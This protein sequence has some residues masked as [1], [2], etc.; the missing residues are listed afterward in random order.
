[1]KQSYK[2]I[3]KKYKRTV[4]VGDI[5]GCFTE[6]EK[7]LKLISFSDD[8]LLIAVGD[9]V[10][11]G[12]RTWDVVRF[13]HDKPNAYSVLGNHDR[14]LAGTIYGT[15]QPAWSQLHSLAKLPEK[16]RLYWANFLG[17][18]PAVIEAE[19]AIVTHARLDP[20]RSIREQDPY[21]TCAVGGPGVI[22]EKN[23]NDIPLWFFEWKEV[24]RENKPICI[25]HVRYNNIELVQKQ[26]YALDTGA[27]NGG[28]L[29][30]VILPEYRIVQIKSKR[31]YYDEARL[32]WSA[33]ELSKFTPE[34]IPI[35]RYFSIKKKDKKN[36]CE[37]KIIDEFEKCFESFQFQNKIK[38]LRCKIVKIFGELPLPGPERGKYFLSIKDKFQHINHRIVSIILTPKAFRMEQFLR[39]FEG[40]NLLKACEELERIETSLDLII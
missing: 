19:H 4:V 15:S 24:V 14:R 10:D 37:E 36:K 17:S 35:H 31:N 32:E 21:F 1:M 26:L 5:H 27:A 3:T 16:E 6:L 7:L 40:Q 23:E 2:R 13:F 20:E 34:E 22:I 11:R 33:I 18:L 9:L 29:A 30:A 12:P 38:Q 8:D 25:G 39:I 28:Q